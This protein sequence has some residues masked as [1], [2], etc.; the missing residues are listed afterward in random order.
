M[1]TFH[2]E[3]AP[4]QSRFWRRMVIAAGLVLAAE[5]M[6]MGLGHSSGVKD[7]L[8]PTNPSPPSGPQF[9][10]APV[11]AP[12]PTTPPTGPAP[13]PGVLPKIALSALP[14]AAPAQKPGESY[15]QYLQ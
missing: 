9:G 5:V 10:I 12:T 4:D 11:V 3:I 14:P 8:V 2:A 6:W 15:S 13:T 1:S 7:L